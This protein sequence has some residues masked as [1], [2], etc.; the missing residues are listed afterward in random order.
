MAAADTKVERTYGNWRQPR[1]AGIG[2]LGMIST[3]VLM[4]GII[5]VIITTA[6]LGLLV[7]LVVLVLLAVALG[8]LLLRDQHNKTGLQRIAVRAGWLR[9][10]SSGAHLYR[11]GPLGQ[12][13]W[14]TFQLPGLAAA[15]TLS[16]SE[17]S[18]GRPFALLRVPATGHYTVV[19]VTE[20]DGAAL[21]DQEQLDQWVAHWG[22]WLASLGNEPG[23]VAASVTVETAPDSGA[24]LE[25][26]VLSHLDPQAPAVAEAMLREVISSYPAGS[27]TVRAWVALTFTSAGHAGSKRKDA[28]AMARDLASRLAGLT[29]RLHTTG[30]G[31]AR[32]LTAQGLCEAVRVAYDPAAARLFD[33]ARSAGAVPQ[34]RWS[35]VGPTATQARWGDYHHDSAWSITWEMSAAPR[36]EVASSVL[37]K[38]LGPHPDI[39][40]KRVTLLFQPMNPGRAARVVEADKRD[41]SFRAKSSDRPSERVQRELVAAEATAKEEARGAGLVDFG[42]L[43]TATV[44]DEQRLQDAAAAISTLSA[45]ARILLRPVYGS[46]DSAFAAGLPLGLVLPKHL[47]VPAGVRQ[48][49]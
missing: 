7:G 33:Q 12:S 37:F 17:D 45:S 35:D 8:P 49:L 1:S 2:P 23:L 15:S 27:A 36:G 34:L 11:S 20:P 46:Q 30:A 40:R 21:V 47:S 42:L 10:R 4:G 38:L 13:P 16:E 14:G 24:R 43:V 41:A 6:L 5:V 44:M 18:H 32:P 48:S 26:E 3:L 28:Q 31:A 29:Q 9:A 22:E 39:V 19:L 25:R